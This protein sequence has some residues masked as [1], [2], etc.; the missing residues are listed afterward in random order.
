[1]CKSK[2]Y[3]DVHEDYILCAKPVPLCHNGE[4]LRRIHTEVRPG[5]KEILVTQSERVEITTVLVTHAIFAVAGGIVS[6]LHP[7]APGLSGTCARVRCDCRG[8]HVRL[9]YVHFRAA[10]TIHLRAQ[11]QVTINTLHRWESLA[12]FWQYHRITWHTAF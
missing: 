3:T 10:C 12:Y 1:M 4:W 5:A 8:H 7:S 6:T 9:P 2:N 11:V